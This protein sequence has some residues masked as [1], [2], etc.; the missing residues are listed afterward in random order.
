MRQVR[1]MGGI[2]GL[3]IPR[4][5]ETPRGH[6]HGRALPRNCGSEG[7]SVWGTSHTEPIDKKGC[8]QPRSRCLKVMAPGLHERMM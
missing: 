5:W 6:S 7:R 4:Q 3:R 8:C 1:P 2:G